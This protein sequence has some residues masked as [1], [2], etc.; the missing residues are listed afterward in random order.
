MPYI[1]QLSEYS[2]SN[3]KHEGFSILTSRIL[4]EKQ[5]DELL[6]LQELAIKEICQEITKLSKIGLTTESNYRPEILFFTLIYDNEKMVGYGY[7]WGKIN[8][9]CI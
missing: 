7:A 4:T 1:L 9:R 5:A 2:R 3:K 8:L 6:S